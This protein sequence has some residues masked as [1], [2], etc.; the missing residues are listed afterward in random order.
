MAITACG[1]NAHIINATT[2][3]K[4]TVADIDHQRLVITLVGADGEEISYK[5]TQEQY[6]LGEIAVGDTITGR[7]IRKINAQAIGVEMGVDY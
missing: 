2:G 3:E 1:H 5:A 4:C 6:F 7:E